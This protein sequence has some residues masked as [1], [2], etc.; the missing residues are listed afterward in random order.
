MDLTRELTEDLA[1]RLRYVYAA[2]CLFFCVVGWRLVRLQLVEGDRHRLFALE[3][4]IKSTRVPAARGP[5]LD[6]NGTPLVLNRP[7]VDIVATPQELGD[8]DR[9]AASVAALAGI[10]TEEVTAR[11]A[12]RKGVA[13]YQPIV[14]VE[15]VPYDVVARTRA[16][17]TAWPDP[18][19]PFDLRGIDLLERTARTYPEGGVAPHVVGYLRE[20]DPDE[21][22]AW[23][24]KSPGRL[25][26]GDAIGATGLEAVW[27][28]RLRGRPGYAE[29]L[30]DARGREVDFPELSGQLRRTLPTGGAPLQLTLDAKLQHT[31]IQALHGNTGA[32]VAIDPG[33]G[34]ILALYSAPAYDLV[35]LHGP[36]RRTTWRALLA[37]PDK[38]LLNRA[39]QS[40]YPP[41][42]TYKIVTAAAGL[43]EGVIQPEETIHCSGALA[44]GGRSFGCW[45]RGGHGA[46]NLR[47]ALAESCDVFFYT[48]GLRLGPDRLADYARRFGLGR[49]TGI[50]LPHERGGLIPTT[51]WKLK[52]RKA[53]WQ[54]GETLSI[55]IG[56]GYDSVTPL[57]AAVM[58][59][60]VANGGQPV[61]PHL[62]ATVV[63][64]ETASAAPVVPLPVIETI[65]DGLA[66]VVASPSGTAHFL[67]SLGIPIAGKTGTAQVISLLKGKGHGK[68]AD[69]A[70]FVAYA[71]TDQ[72]KIAIAV[73]VEHGGHGG[74]TAAPI[75]GA[76]IQAYLGK[77]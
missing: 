77:K 64:Q 42:S 59:A 9:V 73:L 53:A 16:W 30:V 25:A 7:A 34:G 12:Q 41:G 63:T 26:A 31:A 4:S 33:T 44:I 1:P 51:E 10:A 54:A 14:L 6:R 8:P 21:L 69:H 46:V 50:D 75:A 70:W 18:G 13:P 71:P 57:Q 55:A 5:I 45:R 36:D 66:Q 68:F 28:E 29:R 32:V 11:L 38:P 22:A 27:D 23:E 35:A 56:Q 3:H 43:T 19:D 17:Q 74:A 24:A 72:P 37:D 15:D 65:R 49:P 20:I 62:V 40:A 58:V 52:N 2:I 76:L 67:M 47:R 48:V 60:T 39:V 61:H